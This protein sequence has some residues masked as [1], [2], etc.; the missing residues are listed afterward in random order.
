MTRR[1]TLTDR[2][3]AALPVRS[4]AYFTADPEMTGFYIRITPNGARSFVA[5]ARDPYGKQIWSTVGSTD[6][7]KIDEARERARTVI[8]RIKDGQPP[9]DAPPPE[10]DSYAAVYANWLQREIAKKNL[11]RQRDLERALTK[12]VLPTFGQRPFTSIRRS[13]ITALLDRIEDKH[14]APTADKALT[15]MR[16]LAD[17]YAKR[18]DDYVTPFVRK[19]NRSS[20]KPRERTLKDDEIRLLWTAAN[21]A[22]TFGAFVK[23]LLLTG[24]RRE[25]VRLMRWDELTDDTGAMVWTMPQAERAKGTA[26]QLKLPPLAADIINA[27]PRIA[28]NPFVFAGRNGAI[29]IHVAHKQL[30][31]PAVTGWRLHDLRRTHRSLLARCGI[32]RDIGE[33]VLGHRIKGV[34]G[35]YNRFDYFEE[36]THA[37]AALAQLIAAMIGGGPANVVQM[38]RTV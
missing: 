9:K 1:K 14:G 17:W 2:M 7:L 16:S 27:L 38:R 25:A 33:R 11:I 30:R 5:V 8:R 6:H 31:C 15:Y 29:A 26:G 24:Q 21:A 32:N 12:Y 22:G 4:K 18:D 13:D 36:K 10:P 20:N 19:M 37:L 34:E 3:L 28:D 35:T 23:M